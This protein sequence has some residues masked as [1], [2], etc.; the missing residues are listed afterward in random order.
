MQQRYMQLLTSYIFHLVLLLSVCKLIS[1]ILCSPEIKD[2][3]DYGL[4]ICMDQ[5]L[6]TGSDAYITL[7]LLEDSIIQEVD[8]IWY[9]SKIGS[10]MW[11]AS[12]LRVIPEQCAKLSRKY[13]VVITSFGSSAAFPVPLLY[14]K[15]RFNYKH[16]LLICRQIVRCLSNVSQADNMNVTTNLH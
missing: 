16:K 3:T 15:T 5:P 6:P 8:N 12:V 7:Q 1:L 10:G 9:W 14:N 2:Y 4:H 13:R 11:T